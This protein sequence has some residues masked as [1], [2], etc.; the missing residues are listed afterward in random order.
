MFSYRHAFHAGNHADVLKHVVLLDVLKYVCQKET[1]LFYID[2]HAGAGLYQ[3]EQKEAQKNKEFDSGITKLWQQERVLPELND[4]MQLIRGLNLDHQLRYYPGSPYIASQVLREKDRL[5][6]FEWHPTEIDVLKQNFASENTPRKK[7]I[8]I[9]HQNGFSSLKGLLPPP[10]RR[11]VILMDPSY[12][13]KNDYALTLQTLQES[14]KRFEQGI[15][16]VWYPILSR[17]EA[18]RFPLQLKQLPVKAW[19]EV[20]LCIR[21][22][23]PD[24]IGLYGS[25]MF[26]INPP[27]LLKSYLEKVMPYLTKVLGEDRFAQYTLTSGESPRAK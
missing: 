3:L 12:E 14:L 21:Q 20:S 19:L 1:M 9:E 4:Y 8:L 2:T 24:G 13:N 11:A 6:L 25:A 23:T 15:Y 10:S 5:R 22:I 27:W 7:R 17:Q 16:M 18:K 26:I